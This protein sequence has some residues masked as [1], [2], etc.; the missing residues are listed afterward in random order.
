MGN[1]VT[2]DELLEW[3]K[4][5]I[6]K[7]DKETIKELHLGS[8]VTQRIGDGWV[9]SPKRTT[10]ESEGREVSIESHIVESFPCGTADNHD[11]GYYYVDGHGSNSRIK[12]RYYLSAITGRHNHN[13]RR[14][15]T[16]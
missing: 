15:H 16:C 8:G 9:S 10:E 12:G 14:E 2:F 6:K 4:I 13:N 11:Q 3:A 7:L 1:K 5:G